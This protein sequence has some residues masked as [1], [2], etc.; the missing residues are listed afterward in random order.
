MT[1]RTI[2]GLNAAIVLPR[3]LMKSAGPHLT[4]TSANSTFG[5]LIRFGEPRS[6]LFWHYITLPAQPVDILFVLPSS[7]ALCCQLFSY[8]TAHACRT[9]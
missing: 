4:I 7:E 5:S 9:G 3:A 8:G 2:A 1:D 6:D